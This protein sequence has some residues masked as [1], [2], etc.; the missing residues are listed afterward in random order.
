VP[1]AADL[2]RRLSMFAPNPLPVLVT[3]GFQMTNAERQE[4]E[5]ACSGPVGFVMKPFCD[6]E[7]ALALIQASPPDLFGVPRGEDVRQRR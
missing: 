2:L 6:E 7:L 4:I 1:E 5:A 3:T